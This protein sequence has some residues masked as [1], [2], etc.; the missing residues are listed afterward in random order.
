MVRS[1]NSENR[2]ADVYRRRQTK[3]PAAAIALAQ[4]VTNDN[5]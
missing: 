1:A 5:A 4:L 3:S 2:E